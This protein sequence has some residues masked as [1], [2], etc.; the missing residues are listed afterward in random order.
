MKTKGL[1]K[2]LNALLSEEALMTSEEKGIKVIDINELEP[3][4]EQP[5][6]RF[7]QEELNELSFSIQEH[8]ILQPLIVRQKGEKYQIIAGERRY[9]A[10][11]QAKLRE[12]PIIIKNFDDKQTLEVSII[13]NIQRQ[14]LNAMELACAYSLL[15][16]RFDL[17]QEQVADRV[18]KSRPSVANIMRLM[19][20]NPYVQQKLRDDEI[21]FGHARAIL[22]IA[23]LNT[24]KKIVDLV[25]ENNWSVR[26]TE[27]Y[28][29]NKT[30]IQTNKEEKKVESNPFYKEIQENLQKTLGTKV[31]ISNGKKKGKIEI[32]YYSENELA[33]I[34]QMIQN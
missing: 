20:L 6:K 13:E 18:G 33:R 34:I 31:T 10:A 5:R 30:Q 9:K 27:K 29:K 4:F 16:E 15:M 32:E 23:D 2:G 7:T 24:Q 11:R 3:N 22:S 28:I 8:G 17:N 19:K 26:E 1:G 12:V 21:S 25:I 14:D